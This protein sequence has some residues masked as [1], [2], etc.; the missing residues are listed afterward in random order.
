MGW[1]RKWVDEHGAH[2]E[3][4]SGN[5]ASYTF[6][7]HTPA[8]K[9]EYEVDKSSKKAPFTTLLTVGAIYLAGK[10]LSSLFSRDD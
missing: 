7:E 6:R 10:L 2:R 9:F 5:R 1:S 4:Y 3:R 8:Q